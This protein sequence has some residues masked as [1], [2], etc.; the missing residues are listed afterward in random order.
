MISLLKKT[1]PE[2]TIKEILINQSNDFSFFENIYLENTK[3]KLLSKHGS[4][5]NINIHK[6]ISI[7]IPVY[8]SLKTLL[9]TLDSL[10]FQKISETEYKN[11]EVVIADDG[12]TDNTESVLKN[13]DYKFKLVYV[14]QKNIGSG[15][16]RNLG[17]KKSTG[18]ILIFLDSD[19]ILQDNFIRE[20]AIRNQILD[21]C[22]FIGFREHLSMDNLESTIK[23]KKP[24][25]T[26]DVRFKR[27]F[28]RK[29]KRK[30]RECSSDNDR[31]IK[32]I[33][34]TSFFKCFGKDKVLGAWDLPSMVQTFSLS[35]RRSSFIKT[36]GF[37][38]KFKGWGM[39]DTFFGACLIATGN[40]IIPVLSTGVFH[41]EHNVRSGSTEKKQLEFDKNV[42][43]YNQLIQQPLNKNK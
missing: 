42:K 17:V 22:C 35:L 33:E 27:S 20:H 28:S 36:E 13:K 30:H 41:I 34:E 9:I 26:N 38:L 8:N 24:T 3:R 7:I 12:S 14:R 6:K 19:V 43:I 23:N 10:N 5:I 40:F 11:I 15:S 32:I 21:N 16:A 4:K 25:I 39:E 31:E 2:Y 18:E 37:S 1:E 29:W